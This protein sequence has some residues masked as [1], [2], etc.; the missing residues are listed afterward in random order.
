MSK[1]YSIA[2]YVKMMGSSLTKFVTIEFARPK[3]HK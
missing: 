3:E 1:F 2:L